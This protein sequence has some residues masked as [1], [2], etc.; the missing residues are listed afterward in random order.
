MLQDLELR[1]QVKAT[2]VCIIITCAMTAILLFQVVSTQREVRRNA[3]S[4]DRTT[5]ALLKNRRIL[6]DFIDRFPDKQIK[7]GS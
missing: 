2:Q 6:Q 5:S 7:S 3:M 4:L 1:N